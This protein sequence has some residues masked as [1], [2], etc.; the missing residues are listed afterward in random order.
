MAKRRIRSEEQG[1]QIDQRPVVP[2][3]QA[4]F[5]VDRSLW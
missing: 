4:S 1:R 2:L 5:R 3:A